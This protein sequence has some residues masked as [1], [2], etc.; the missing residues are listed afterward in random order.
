MKIRHSHQRPVSIEFLTICRI[1]EF[2]K[3]EQNRKNCGNVRIWRKRAAVRRKNH[4]NLNKSFGMNL[5]LRVDH[6][7]YLSA[8]RKIMFS[9]HVL[10]P[11]QVL[12]PITIPQYSTPSLCRFALVCTEKTSTHTGKAEINQTMQRFDVFFYRSLKIYSTNILIH[13]VT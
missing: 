8:L 4:S 5:L 2:P 12:N 6:P 7:R 1:P 10:T 3:S 13:F 9:N 11:Y